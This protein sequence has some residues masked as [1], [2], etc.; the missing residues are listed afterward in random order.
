M[1]ILFSRKGFTLLE[2]L[3][4]IFI[5]GLILAI[6]ISMLA[7]VLPSQKVDATAREMIATFR[8]ARSMAMTSG[9]WQVLTLDMDSRQYSIEGGSARRFIPEEVRVEVEDPLH[10]EIKRGDYRFIFAPSGASEG[11][12]V[13]LS[14]G[15][16]IVDLEIDPIVGAVYSYPK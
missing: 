9:Q 6:S 16:K 14:S 10:G 8:L 12:R 13:V 4:V 7:N 1:T 5:I 11:A 2:I 15:K 3:L